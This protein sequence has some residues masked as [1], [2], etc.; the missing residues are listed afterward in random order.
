MNRLDRL[1]NILTRAFGGIVDYNEGESNSQMG[2]INSATSAPSH[3]KSYTSFTSGHDSSYYSQFTPPMSHNNIS[4]IETNNSSRRNSRRSEIIIPSDNVTNVKVDDT[5]D[6]N[7]PLKGTSLETALVKENNDEIKE[8]SDVIED[9]KS[10]GGTDV[11]EID[12]NVGL[13]PVEESSVI[14][15]HS[16]EDQSAHVTMSPSVAAS[17][18]KV[19][20]AIQSM[21]KRINLVRSSTQNSPF[22]GSPNL[23]K[24]KVDTPMTEEVV[25]PNKNNNNNSECQDDDKNNSKASDEVKIVDV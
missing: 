19:S 4:N 21:E 22:N 16:S 13:P 8:Q 5:N 11:K 2:G 15:T 10:N 25:N 12:C 20:L 14:E 6:V 18:G 9:T 3:R 7:T 23:V 24:K 1:E 17:V